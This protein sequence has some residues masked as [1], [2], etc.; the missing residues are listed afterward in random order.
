M[1][2]WFRV[3]MDEPSRLTSVC[4]LLMSDAAVDSGILAT[5]LFNDPFDSL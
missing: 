3:A 1:Y 2:L 5:M 4:D